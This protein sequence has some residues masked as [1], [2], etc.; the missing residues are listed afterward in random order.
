MILPDK[1]KPL[2][3]SYDSFGFETI[4]MD[5]QTE[6]LTV[7]IGVLSSLFFHFSIILP[8]LSAFNNFGKQLLPIN[9]DKN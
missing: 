4:L 5:V 8:Y 3:N 1:T 2:H 7:F 6:E 9:Y